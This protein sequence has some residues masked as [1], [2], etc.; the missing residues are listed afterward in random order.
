MRVRILLCC[1]LVPSWAFAA[2]APRE[3]FLD[4]DGDHLPYR[5]DVRWKAPAYDVDSINA[6]KIT[7]SGILIE[8]LDGDGVSE[9]VQAR[10]GAI[11]AMTNESHGFGRNLWWSVLP[12]EYEQGWPSAYLAGVA[13][14]DGDG[15]QEVLAVCSDA[16]HRLMRLRV[17][18]GDTGDVVFDVPLLPSREHHADGIWDGFYGLAGALEV[19]TA[20]GPRPAYALFASAGHDRQPRGV[21]AVDAVSGE[22]LWFRPMAGRINSLT[23]AVAD[24]EGDGRKEV[25]AVTVAV[26]NYGDDETVEGLRDDAVR[27][28]VLEADGAERWRHEYPPHAGGGILALADLDGDGRQEVLCGTTWSEDV[29]NQL[30]VFGSGDGA[31]LD[32]MVVDSLLQAIKVRS[33]TGERPA[34]LYLTSSKGGLSA[35]RWGDGR[36]TLER[37]LASDLMLQLALVQ[38]LLP[39]KGEELVLVLSSTRIAVLDERFR[40]LALSEEGKL[41]L[42]RL[43]A[44]RTA[45]GQVMILT[46]PTSRTEGIHFALATAPRVFDPRFYLLGALPLAALGVAVQ[47]RRRRRHAAVAVLDQRDA[48]LQLL[49]QLELANH[50]AIGLLK[51]LRRVVWL[52]KAALGAVAPVP[53][54]RMLEL[55]R[56]SLERSLPAVERMLQLA[57]AAGLEARTVLRPKESLALVQRELKDLQDAGFDA[58]SL[59]EHLPELEAAAL[60]LERDLQRLRG[61]TAA[62][63]RSDL[64]VAV[65]RVL[66]LLREEIQAAGVRI[67]VD[68]HAPARLRFDPEELL[69]VLDD[70]VQNALRAMAPRGGDLTLAW[71]EDEGS[72]VLDVTDTGDGIVPDDWERIFDPGYS[73]RAGGGLGLGRSRDLLRKYEGTIAVQASEP[74]RGTTMRLRL[75]AARE[76]G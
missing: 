65:D 60:D 75:A 26:N 59:A 33:A 39:E 67:H 14:A 46:S 73:T 71:R 34:R 76:P 74:G 48:R 15:T 47:R 51:T 58:P 54:E 72:V 49:G 18:R 70:L 3:R 4:L 29:G 69:F 13:D 50:G 17:L 43:Q 25:V 64:A 30:T 24:L 2:S 7:L 52:G 32:A 16:D 63:F 31:V 45:E 37:H 1:L 22:I 10:S 27:V 19:P 21:L 38:D 5:L 56:E 42:A 53:R 12:P 57:G 35:Y 28:R 55:G 36:W 20:E 41:I 6:K 9:K 44:S 68:D 11:T 61:E 8:D 40:T 23:V 62:H 66:A